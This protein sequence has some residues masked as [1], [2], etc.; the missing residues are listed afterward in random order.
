MIYI[1]SYTLIFSFFLFLLILPKVKLDKLIILILISP[2]IH[3]FADSITNFFEGGLT[4]GVVRA[5]IYLII[6]FIVSGH[7]KF[8]GITF[9]IYIFLF[10]LA[11]LIPLSSNIFASL[12]EY[13]K[14][15]ISMMMFPVGYYIVNSTSRLNKIINY[16]F[17]GALIICIQLIIAQV[18]KIGISVYLEDSF[19]LGG[20]LVQVTYFLVAVCLISPFVIRF[21]SNDKYTNIKYFIILISIIL[22]LVAL[23]RISI[24]ALIGGFGVYYIF[25]VNKMKNFKYIT[26][27]ILIILIL[28]PVYGPTLTERIDARIDS[29]V[30]ITEESRFGETAAVYLDFLEVNLTQKLFGA[31]LFNSEEYFAY[32]PEFFYVFGGRRPLHIDYNIILH[33]SGLIGLLL[34]I[35]LHF[36]ILMKIV[37]SKVTDD[38]SKEIK[39]ILYSLFFI[40]ILFPLSG[41]IAG[42]GF[43]SILFLLFGSFL[44]ILYEPIN[45]N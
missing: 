33:G 19:Y 27:G 22:T 36:K 2:F 16:T 20:A 15:F 45:Q 9:W 14:V 34:Y 18:F 7:F 31:E 23:R 44:S 38:D 21:Q 40:L 39:A 8:K 37:N 13:L 1:L 5:I 12:N 6:I 4:P 41:S 3:A 28:L 25:S 35:I 26:A 11:L 24:A 29:T 43:R 10:Y 32:D 17:L 42:I 30:E